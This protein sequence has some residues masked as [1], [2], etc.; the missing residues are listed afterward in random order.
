MKIKFAFWQINEIT[1]DGSEIATDIL[2][3]P[4]VVPNE[5]VEVK[6]LAEA[7]AAREAYVARAQASGYTGRVL[8]YKALGS[9]RAFPGFIPFEGKSILVNAHG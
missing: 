4:L 3:R 6:N 8:T 7:T 1:P 2:T 5:L 9:G